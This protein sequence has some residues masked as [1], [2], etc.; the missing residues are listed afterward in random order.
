MSEQVQSVARALDLLDAIL[1]DGGK[2]PLQ[3]L[4]EKLSIPLP[5]ATRLAAT[6]EQ[7]AFIT[8]GPRGRYV[9]GANLYRHGPLPSPAKVAS[10]FARPALERLARR[11]RCVAHLGTYDGQMVTYHVRAGEDDGAVHTEEGTQLEAYC[12]A[13]GKVL[14]AQ[15]PAADKERYVASGPFVALT[16]N[17]ITNP[18]ALLAELESVRAAGHARDDREIAEDLFCLAVPVSDGQGGASAALSL[19]NRGRLPTETMVER[20]LS[21][22]HEAAAEVAERMTGWNV[23]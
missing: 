18:G 8:R 9:P 2:Q 13:I 1:A 21:A 11:F 5:T 6:L 23:R 20:R 16:A 10:I 12:S 3:S 19:S 4:C 7:K 22:L 17:T 15:L 14:L